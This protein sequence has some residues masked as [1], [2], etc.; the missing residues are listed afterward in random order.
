MVALEI[1]G[2]GLKFTPANGRFTESIEVSIV[3]ADEKAKVQGGDRQTFNL[4]LLPQTHDLVVKNGVRTLSML[5]LPPGRYQIRVGASEATGKAVGTVPYDLEVPDYTKTP[6]ALSGVL[7]TSSSAAAFPTPNPETDWNGLL[8]APPVVT[9]TFSPSDTLTWF[10]EIYDSSNQ[11]AHTIT[12][13]TS[14]VDASDGR[15]LI[16]SRDNRVMQPPPRGQTA[17]AQGFTTSLPLRDLKAGK[18]ILR[19]EAASGGGQSA[20]RDILFDI[21]P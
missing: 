13:T 18:Y 6:F 21:K 1:D 2:S 20:S 16:Q 7:I 10:A 8:P 19:V 9:R 12:Y 3:A 14:V 11:G 5:A 17:P 4:N 15:M